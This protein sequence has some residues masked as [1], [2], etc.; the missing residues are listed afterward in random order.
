LKNFN[1]CKITSKNNPNS[2]KLQHKYKNA[3]AKLEG[4]PKSSKK[5][6]KTTTNGD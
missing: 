6:S 2:R 4:D 1:N 5:A 3:I